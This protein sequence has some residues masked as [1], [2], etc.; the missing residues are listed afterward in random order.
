[1]RYTDE[2]LESLLAGI[3][4]DRAERKESWKGDAP[5]SGR[6]ATCA[7]ANDL[8][9]HREPGVLF[10][11][12]RDNGSPSNLPISDEL[13]RTLSDIRT[14][15]NILPPPSILVEKRTLRGAEM[16]VVT[17]QP[18][19]T[20]P[21]RS[22]GRIWVRIGP[23]R[24]I[25]TPQEERILNEKRRFRDLPF[26]VQ[27]VPTCNLSDLNRLLFEQEYLPNAFAPDVIA[28]NER[29]YEQRLASCRMIAFT[30]DPTPTILGI[31]VLGISPQDWI[32]G[33]Y[34]QFLRIA[35]N[36]MSD[37]IQ[38]GA[39]IDGTINEILRELMKR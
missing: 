21:V 13:L 18:S 34:V 10:I 20:P 31:L 9:D 6:Q 38:D 15:G 25:A 19:D 28:A 3:E 29:S 24:A 4:S 27:P 35:G 23:R 12:A 5:D 37:D 22:R 33:S 17:V 1:M 11:G 8:P 2:Q 26:D 16:A 39:R 14:D 7:F 30:D 32:P 36:N